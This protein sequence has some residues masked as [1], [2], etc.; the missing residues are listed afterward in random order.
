MWVLVVFFFPRKQGMTREYLSYLQTLS[1]GWDV[2][3]SH[4]CTQGYIPGFKVP[5]IVQEA[6]FC[7]CL[8]DPH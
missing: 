1:P 8:P 5:E 3:P 2:I 7:M 6:V 4:G